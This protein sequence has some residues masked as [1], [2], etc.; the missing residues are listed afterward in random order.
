MIGFGHGDGLGDHGGDFV[1]VLAEGEDGVAARGELLEGE[2]AVEA[3][4]HVVA[5]EVL[6][7]PLDVHTLPVGP[8]L[9]NHVAVLVDVVRPNVTFHDRRSVSLAVMDVDIRHC[10]GFTALNL[11]RL[12]HRS[13][14][15]AR[16]GRIGIN[17]VGA[18]TEIVKPIETGMVSLLIITIE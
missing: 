18:W 15:P 17:G 6:T 10:C 8:A 5:R 3:G 2:H 13:T 16:Q 14:F 4:T 11:N 12:R 9:R 7:L 1:A